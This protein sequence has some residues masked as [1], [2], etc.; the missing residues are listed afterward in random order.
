LKIKYRIAEK[1][2]PA[3]SGVYMHKIYKNFDVKL[4]TTLR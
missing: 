4:I 2:Y 1:I 3:N